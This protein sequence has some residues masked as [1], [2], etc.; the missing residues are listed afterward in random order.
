ML[1]PCYSCCVCYTS[2]FFSVDEGA[3]MH[4]QLGNLPLS[5]AVGYDWLDEQFE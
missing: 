4:C 2:P 1:L 3:D 5:N